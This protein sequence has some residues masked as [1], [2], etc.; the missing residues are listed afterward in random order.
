MSFLA[1]TTVT[2]TR[3]TAANDYG[4][5]IDTDEVVAKKV[6]ASILEQPVS[7]GRPASG[8]ADTPRGYAMRVW[9]ATDLRQDD[10]ITDERTGHTFYVTSLN[11]STNPVGLG[12]TRAVL[13]RVT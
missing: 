10:R 12:S 9:G 2:I 4:D 11:P 13:Q 6:R 8:R 1:T 3:G 7:G 5:E